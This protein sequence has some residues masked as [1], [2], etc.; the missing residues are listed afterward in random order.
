M[1]VSIDLMLLRFALVFVAASIFGLQRQKA[2]KPIGFG[3][4]IF[5]AI[6]ACGAAILAIDFA[7]ENPLPTL[8]AVMTGIGFLG[9]GA[10]IKTSDKV[11][12]FT[13]AATVWLFA[14]FGFIMGTGEYLIG[15]TIFVMIWL[16]IAIDYHLEKKGI[17]AYQRKLILTTCKLLPEREINKDIMMYT[18]RHKLISV[19][20]DKKNTKMILTYIIEGSKFEI[21]RLPDKLYDKNWFDGAKIE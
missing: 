20:I 7:P 14:V 16:I 9:A 11:L 5:V 18:K 13:S 6:G 2:H 10:L 19:E 3:T 15:A 4:Y 1:K 17:G 8:S 21:N 12:G